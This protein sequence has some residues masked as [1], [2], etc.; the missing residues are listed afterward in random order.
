MQIIKSIAFLFSKKCVY[1]LFP[2]IIIITVH[3]L[4]SKSDLII[5]P[6]TENS[7][8]ISYSD[9]ISHYDFGN[10]EIVSFAVDSTKVDLR[11]II[12]NKNPYPYSGIQWYWAS[13]DNFLDLSKYQYVTISFDTL[14]TSVESLLL[15]IQVFCDGFSDPQNTMSWRFL[16][17]E[18]LLQK[19]V[20]NYN[21]AISD[22]LTPDWWYK[23]IKTSE[24]SLGKPDFKNVGSISIQSS[25]YNLEKVDRFVIR[26]LRFHQKSLIYKVLLYFCLLVGYFALYFTAITFWKIKKPVIIPIAY[27]KIEIENDSDKEVNNI[28]NYI[29][30]NYSNP[31]LNLLKMSIELGIS[32]KKI[33]ALIKKKHHMSFKQYLNCIRIT[34]AKRLI[35]ESDLQ[36]NQIA[37][38]V[39]YGNTAH[40]NR[41][42]KEMTSFTPNS[43]REKCKA[44]S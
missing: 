5:F 30:K 11:Y 10:S 42:F 38:K 17:K 20:S 2:V 22:F 18:L 33:S 31:T 25:S 43:F 13:K 44:N 27:Q 1:L 16:T 4:T 14:K 35:T 24:K 39:G 26:G 12:R 40:F 28:L 23:K 29:G 3:F 34:E 15:I 21:I 37:Y 19:G 7:N 32:G 8:L 41:T 36:I 9:A 6:N